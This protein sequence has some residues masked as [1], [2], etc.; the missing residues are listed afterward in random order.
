[1]GSAHW[2]CRQGLVLE[3]LKSYFTV[4]V[5]GVGVR[6]MQMLCD[7]VWLEGTT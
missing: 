7:T 1:M 5:S 2:A 4:L 3:R 6:G